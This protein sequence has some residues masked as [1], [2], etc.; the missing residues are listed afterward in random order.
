MSDGLI[1]QLEAATEGGRELDAAIIRHLC[2]NA[3]IGEYA[4][5]EDIVF[6]A[7]E[8]GIPDKEIMP[9]FTESIDAAMTLAG[10][11]DA[12]AVGV[13]LAAIEE[14][15]CDGWP[16][17]DWLMHLPRYICLAAMKGKSK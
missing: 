5:Y 14:L 13:L 6:H 16:K 12:E 10:K 7:R 4:G 15:E 1:A 11:S 9:F 17:G 3:Q 8:I 2:P